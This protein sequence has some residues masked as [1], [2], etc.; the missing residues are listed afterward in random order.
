MGDVAKVSTQDGKVSIG[1]Y[2][3]SISRV[4][5]KYQN[6]E[7]KKVEVVKETSDK[8]TSYDTFYQPAVM[9]L[10]KMYEAKKMA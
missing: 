2:S 7:S 8:D 6:Y 5:L 3:T 10:L 1:H 9:L 4:N